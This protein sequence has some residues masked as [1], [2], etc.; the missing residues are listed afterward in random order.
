M[1]RRNNH[2]VTWQTIHL[3]GALLLPDLLE[4]I[5]KNEATHQKEREYQIPAGLRMVEEIGRSY[6]IARALHD[7]FKKRQQLA[8]SDAFSLTEGFITKFMSNCLGWNSLKKTP[9]K[10]VGEYSFPIQR[11]AYEHVP[12]SIGPYDASVD[13]LDSRFA[14]RGGRK[15]RNRSL[16]QMGQEYLN[17]TGKS[18]WGLISNGNVVRLLRSS[19]TLARPQYLEF[20]LH[21]ILE[22]DH[23]AE[24]MLLWKI[25]H[26]SRIYDTEYESV[27]TVWEEW[28]NETISTGERVRDG[29]RDGVT[30]ALKELGSG[31]LA[32][33]GNT[34]L[35]RKLD[36]GEMD[37]AELYHQLL[38]LVYRF[39]F[40]F[41]LEERRTENGLRL[42]FDPDPSLVDERDLY[43]RGYS[44]DR[45]R[46]MM[47]KR[48]SYN[49]YSDLW[50]TQQIVFESLA[51]G[52]RRL[53]LPALG[54]LFGK[55]VCVDLD[56]AIVDNA[57]FLKAMESL[58][59]A[60]TSSGQYS[61]VDYRNMGT[62][63]LGSV[64]ESLLELVPVVDLQAKEFRFVGID[65]DESTAGNVRKSTGSYYTPSFLV[66]QLIK[67][68]LVPV[69]ERTIEENPE[70]AE[71][72]ILK[73]S[74]IDPACGS[75]HFLLAAARKTAEYLAMVRNPDGTITPQEYRRAVKDVIHRCIY[76]VDLNPMA[77]EL[78]KIALWL[79]GYEPGK[80]LGFLD[81]HLVCGNSV[82]GMFDLNAL[83]KGIPNDAFKQLS[84]DD[85]HVCDQ[86]RDTN[87]KGLKEFKRREDA[88][89]QQDF[90]TDE[91]S[92]TDLF[93]VLETMPEESVEDIEAK[94]LK[95][96]ELKT[97]MGNNK[98]H[99]AADIIL[100]AFLMQKVPDRTIPTS[101]TLFRD[102]VLNQ[103]TPEDL[104]AIKE[105]RSAC[106]EAKALHWPLTFP[107]ILSRGG[108][109]VVLGNPPWEKITLKEQE[110]F[111]SRSPSITL[112]QNAA[113]R[114]AMIEAL[115]RGS[116][117]DKK[118]YAEFT[119]AKR[120]AEA[121]ST[122]IHVKE[123]DGGQYPLSGIKDT[124][125]YALFADLMNKLRNKKKGA[126]GVIV[127]TGIATDDS[128]KF[129]FG[130]FVD[131]E[132]LHSLYDFEN[133]EKVFPAVDSRQKFSLLTLGDVASS[134]FA[135]FLLNVR[136]LEDE[137][138]H[139][140]L[141]RNDFK[142]INPNTL[143][144]PV[145]RSKKDAELTKKIYRNTPV[146]INEEL[147]EEGNPWGVGFLRMFDMA[148]DSSLFL[149]APT[150][151]S[152]P[153]YEAK[154]LHQYDH[155]W[156]T[157]ELDG[158]TRDVTPSEKMD[159]S[160]EVTPR[161]WV[162]KREVL[163]RIADIPDAVRKA[164]YAEEEHQ[165]RDA[166][167]TCA[168]SGLRNLALA[169]DIW[170]RMD[171]VMDERS[172]K[173]LIGWRKITNTTNE[174]TLI[175]FPFPR[176]GL[177]DSG[178]VFSVESEENILLVY[179]LL[180]SIVLD[181]VVRQKV[182]GTN[183]NIFYIKQFPIIPFGRIREAG[184]TYLKERVTRLISTSTNMTKAIG[185]M[186]QIWDGDER[187]VFR[188]EIDSLVAR[189][190]G[191]TRED[192]MYILDPES[193]M[194]EGY[195]SQ[196]FPGL[197]RREL[198]EF[199]EYRTMR[200]VLEAWDRQEQ[201]P[202]LWQ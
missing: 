143:T 108:F 85:K 154:M 120:E 131:S 166:L 169:N 42:I 138:R 65:D 171:R 20:D 18:S 164:W 48:S 112:A 86:L 24:Y 33:R 39:L 71:E 94:Q 73:L 74:I 155:R 122:F 134:D 109:D 141:T 91:E 153:L 84:G 159:H 96:Q 135:C 187:A 76:G 34:E 26:V 130:S 45:L 128:T 101:Q 6:Q 30:K 80:P 177:G 115:Q 53:A 144:L 157:Y 13:T 152:Y 198:K 36:E 1:A 190:Y 160:F 126:S 68:A 186:T 10:R 110:F 132:S 41:A 29:L 77:L 72:A 75:G 5:A 106:R 181:F 195:P 79:E 117:V 82:L 140:E 100:G 146:L 197:K 58:R 102:Y 44:L 92:V 7:D 196:T 12:L 148:N 184:S 168:D 200:L 38:H 116:E 69:V 174:R 81:R 147:G 183:L 67:T 113:K 43:E 136:D 51:R 97:L 88:P 121:L 193:V 105:A 89:L 161:Y 35:R 133:R 165:L 175:A 57:V 16:F 119:M 56:T 199:G 31:F 172:P 93:A 61:Y 23:Y 3:E 156:A 95:Y 182:G 123:D 2:G 28:R 163:N 151:E 118:L 63:E 11:I 129:L 98:K 90:L 22:D 54:G 167:T 107:K 189:L 19:P 32:H 103:P 201:E 60:R 50:Q 125:L 176:G 104:R 111:A 47:L 66:D 52:E 46:Q 78:T 127:P 150:P 87:K 139:F 62:E 8:S 40:L 15:D 17:A 37:E 25:L 173:W 149:D 191:L 64:Y 99:V 188:A 178:I 114:K 162:A 192:L 55:D 145:F 137:N 158:T 170:N 142:L 124:N 179:A 194:G 4:Q 202:E 14:V 180:N 9:N 70:N 49:L 185:S 21:A 83:D 59:W 27:M